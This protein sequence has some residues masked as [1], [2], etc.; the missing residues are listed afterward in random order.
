MLSEICGVIASTL[1]D[2][3]SSEPPSRVDKVRNAIFRVIQNV[4]PTACEIC[5]ERL[6]MCRWL[7]IKLSL[8]CANAQDLCA[9]SRAESSA[10]TKIP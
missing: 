1:N 5:R 10:H 2:D 3:K 4:A 6:R 9:T 7:A 8:P